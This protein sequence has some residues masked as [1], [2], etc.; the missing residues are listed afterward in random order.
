MLLL[1]DIV[2]SQ[3]TNQTQIIQITLYIEHLDLFDKTIVVL[4]I[5]LYLVEHYY[6]AT[7]LHLSVSKKE[8]E[9]RFI[10]QFNNKKSPT[11]VGLF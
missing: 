11:N 8:N 3:T 7:N 10:E 4:D 5:M 6:D 2:H 1:Y 9:M